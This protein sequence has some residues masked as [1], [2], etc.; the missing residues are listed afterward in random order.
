M[1]GISRK[2]SVTA[3]VFVIPDSPVIALLQR[4]TAARAGEPQSLRL[5]ASNRYRNRIQIAHLRAK[6][7][8]YLQLGTPRRFV[9]SQLCGGRFSG[10]N[11]H[12]DLHLLQTQGQTDLP[13]QGIPIGTMQLMR[14]L[15]NIR[16][17][18]CGMALPFRVANAVHSPSVT[19]ISEM[20]WSR[21]SGDQIADGTTETR[22]R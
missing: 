12:M 3:I 6:W 5:M 1:K 4:K 16:A 13:Q 19:N 21:K 18:D 9:G 7:L 22:R 20:D 11:M 10:N 14:G 2:A 15:C 17:P 8:N